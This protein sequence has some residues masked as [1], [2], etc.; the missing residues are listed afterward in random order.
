M[1][2]IKLSTYVSGFLF[3]LA[4]TLAAYFAVV[5]HVWNGGYLI[6]FV[7]GLALV[8]L[9]VQLIFFLHLNNESH[10]RWNLVS[11]ISTLSVISLLVVGSLWIM[12]HLNYNMMTTP[13]EINTY[14]M[15]EE[16]IQP[17]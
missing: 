11:L 10:P 4:L 15:Q 5:N 3:S 14:I 9:V 17:E 7:V 2:K 1:E 6:A 13:G 12:G 16:G 8:Q